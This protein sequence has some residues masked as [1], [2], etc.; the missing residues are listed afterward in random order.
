MVRQ[1]N[2]QELLQEDHREKSES[3]HARSPTPL[4]PSIPRPEESG[5]ERNAGQGDPTLM[6]P[7][8]AQ[9][10]DGGLDEEFSAL[11]GLGSEGPHCMHDADAPMHEDGV[12]MVSLSAETMVARQDADVPLDA[13]AP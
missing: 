12:F 1:R 5:E 6:S 11:S 8:A 10:E 13:P 4:A 3:D 2:G 7:H 9:I